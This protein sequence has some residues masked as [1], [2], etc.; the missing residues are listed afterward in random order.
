M[1]GRIVKTSSKHFHQHQTSVTFLFVFTNWLFPPSPGGRSS[2]R[3]HLQLPNEPHQPDPGACAELWL[4]SLHALLPARR[5]LA[6]FHP[7]P[8]VPGSA[9]SGGKPGHD[10]QLGPHLLLL[11][12]G[13]HQITLIFLCG[14]LFSPFLPFIH[15]FS[16]LSLFSSW[17][18]FYA[19]NEPDI[20]EGYS[21]NDHIQNL[22]QVIKQHVQFGY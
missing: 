3:H 8:E 13:K 14:L 9:L 21:N 11:D 6:G 7:Q 16:H 17:L 22:I 2:Q 19:H 10:R 1:E 15:A 20:I 4:P 18:F 5:Y 12:H